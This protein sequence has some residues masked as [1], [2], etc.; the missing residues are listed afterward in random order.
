MQKKKIAKKGKTLSS[1]TTGA[2]KAKPLSRVEKG[3]SPKKESKLELKRKKINK[4]IFWIAWPVWFVIM[5]PF[6]LPNKCAAF[7]E[8][9]L[10]ASFTCPPISMVISVILGSL[11]MAFLTFIVGWVVVFLKYY[12]QDLTWDNIK[13]WFNE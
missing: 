1:K 6:Y 11:F 9:V 13:N 2:L 5:I 10:H 8:P 12:H 7:F 3:V 4:K